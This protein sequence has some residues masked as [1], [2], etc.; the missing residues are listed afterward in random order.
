MSWGIAAYSLACIFGAAIVRG[1]SGFGFSLLAITS[2]SLA[3]PLASIIP[4][5]FMMEVAA[6]LSLMP[7]VWRDVHWKALI[8]LWLGCALGTPLGVHFLAAVPAAP[9]QI[10]LGVAVLA[11]AALLGSGYVRKSMPT[12]GETIL[13]G[14]IA[15]LLNGAFGIVAPPVVVFFFGSP[16]G[17][18][19]SRASL[20]AFFIGTDGIGLAYLAREGLVTSDGLYF[21]LMLLPML[22]AGQWLGARSFRKSDPAKFRRWALMTLCALALLTGFQGALALAGA[23]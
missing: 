22:L 19:I 10:A 5:V 20:I 7:S 13:T 16:A 17:A 2:L 12:G 8:L 1:Y 6:S 21:F 3:L 18:A 14:G 9:M 4:S 23:S 11:A 15:G